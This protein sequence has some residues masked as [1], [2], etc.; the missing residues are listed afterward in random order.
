[1]RK[2]QKSK[3]INSSETTQKI[4]SN[5]FPDK[6]NNKES[7]RVTRNNR[8]HLYRYRKKNAKHAN[9]R[10]TKTTPDTDSI[11][12]NTLLKCDNTSKSILKASRHESQRH[13]FILKKQKHVSSGNREQ[14]E[15]SQNERCSQAFHFEKHVSSNN[16]ITSSMNTQNNEIKQNNIYNFKPETPNKANRGSPDTDTPFLDIPRVNID[17]SHAK[18]PK[19]KRLQKSSRLQQFT[20]QTKKSSKNQNTKKSSHFLRNRRQINKSQTIKSISINVNG[21]VRFK[22]PSIGNSIISGI[23]TPDVSVHKS[24]MT[25]RGLV[26]AL[27]KPGSK[28]IDPFGCDHQ[29]NLDFTRKL[30]QKKQRNGQL[31]SKIMLSPS[32]PTRRKKT[33]RDQYMN[34]MFDLKQEIK[35]NSKRGKVITFPDFASFGDFDGQLYKKNKLECLTKKEMLERQK[36]SISV[37]DLDKEI[38]RFFRQSPSFY[39]ESVLKLNSVLLE[40]EKDFY[41]AKTTIKKHDAIENKFK[42]KQLQLNKR[43]KEKTNLLA[44]LKFNREKNM[45]F[46][47]QKARFERIHY[48]RTLKQVC[49]KSEA[50]MLEINDFVLTKEGYKCKNQSGLVME[51]LNLLRICLGRHDGDKFLIRKM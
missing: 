49:R 44:D 5:P 22:S 26:D 28:I 18:T 21:S 27:Q 40:L 1:M 13:A 15:S 36:L 41:Q 25:T 46:R 2:Y 47:N 4:T 11:Y 50:E 30:S 45:R 23:N 34:S 20:L 17:Y 33:K 51:E 35:R 43:I 6:L 19:K 24:F 31:F 3:F 12:R 29:S 39:V 8:A 7:I 9:H 48:L 16:L 10:R 42:L 32:K 14:S 37:A 38:N